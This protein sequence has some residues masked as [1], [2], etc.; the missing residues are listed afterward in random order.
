M[1]NFH[2]RGSMGDIIYGLPSIIALKGGNL[3]LKKQNHFDFLRTLLKKQPYIN[4]VTID[5]E[6]VTEIWSNIINL[7]KFRTTHKRDLHKHL[8]ICH[9]ETVNKKYD[10]NTIWIFN[11]APKFKNNIIIQNTLRYHDKEEINWQLLKPYEKECLFIGTKKE[12]EQFFIRSKLN[13][14]YY[15]CK[16]GL[17]MIEIIK[18]SKIFIGNQ[19]VGFAMA[20]AIKHPRVL[21][22]FYKKNNCQP[23]GKNGYTYLTNEI[24]KK[25]I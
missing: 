4:K 23:N 18:G 8:S 14:S 5:N 9:L 22:V 16:D 12:Y 1:N 20:E 24:L 11:I 10:L 15:T 13:I 2:H 6:K 7:D 17:E 3:Y 25:F 21:E 19:S